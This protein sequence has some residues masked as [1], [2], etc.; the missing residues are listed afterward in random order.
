M[1]SDKL[2]KSVVALDL[3]DLAF[4]PVGDGVQIARV[5]ADP[6]PTG[7]GVGVIEFNGGTIPDWTLPYDEVSIVMAGELRVTTTSGEIVAPAGQLVVIP[8]GTTVTYAADPGTRLVYVV[9]PRNWRD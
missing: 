2:A 9:Q 7:F 8:M 3:T 4:A 1:E 5:V 6:M